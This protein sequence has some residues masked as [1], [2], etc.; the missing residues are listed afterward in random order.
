MKKS[1]EIIELTQG[2]VAIVSSEDYDRVAQHSWH[3]H[4]TKSKDKQNTGG[5]YARSNIDGKKVYL[6]R[7]ILGAKGKNHVDHL[8]FDTLDNRRQNLKECS[9]KENSSRRRNCLNFVDIGPK[10]IEI[11]EQCHG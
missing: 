7:F 11:K 2:H 5:P 10:K 9:A 6:H 3:T 1:F 4:R 8:N